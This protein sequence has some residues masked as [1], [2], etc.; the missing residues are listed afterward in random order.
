LTLTEKERLYAPV[1][2]VIFDLDGTVAYTLEDLLVAM[3][4]AMDF[5]GWKEKTRED[6]LRAINYGGRQFVKNCMP[7]ECTSDADLCER[8]YLTYY[9]HYSKHCDELTVLYDGVKEVAD[10]LT[11]YG[12]PFSL[13]TNKEVELASRITDKLLPGRFV[14]RIGDGSR[15]KDGKVLPHKPDPTGAYLICEAMG[16][17]PENVIYIGDSVIDMTTAK[18]GGMRS[19]WVS[20][21]YSVRESIPDEVKPDFIAHKAEDIITFIDEIRANGTL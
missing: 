13:N 12:I 7:T 17:K 15:G 3:N 1:K 21:G 9:D 14:S 18:N 5:Y 6:L 20:W 2:A 10:R 19:I 16:V 4:Y 8:A 11:E